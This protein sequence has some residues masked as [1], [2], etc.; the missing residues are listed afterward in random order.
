MEIGERPRDIHYKT[1][2]ICVLQLIRESGPIKMSSSPKWM[3]LPIQEFDTAPC[4]ITGD[5][6]VGSCNGPAFGQN[7]GQLPALPGW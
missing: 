2:E 4:T 7:L 3:V 6:A 5:Y 1:A